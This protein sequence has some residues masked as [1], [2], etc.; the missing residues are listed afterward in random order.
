MLRMVPSTASDAALMRLSTK[1]CAVSTSQFQMW[2]TI[3][4]GR[5]SGVAS[6]SDSNRLAIVP[7]I[8]ADAALQIPV[9]TASVTRTS[10]VGTASRPPSVAMSD[11]N[12]VSTTPGNWAVV[13]VNRFWPAIRPRDR[14]P[15]GESAVATYPAS[16]CDVVGHPD[17]VRR[18]RHDRIELG[19]RERAVGPDANG[20][21]VRL[22]VEQA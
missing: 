11:A 6:L 1:A 9:A 14:A 7:S 15:P 13:G 12:S 4:P 10:A 17:R 22:E 18:K 5:L 3:A 16:S 19:S 20:E 21:R 2:T 8:H